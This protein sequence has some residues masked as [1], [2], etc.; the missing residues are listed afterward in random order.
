M[1]WLDFVTANRIEYGRQTVNNIYIHCPFCG[2]DDRS[3][4][5]GL[6]LDSTAF[7]CWR[8]SEHRGRN[9]VRLIQELLGCDKDDAISLARLYFQVNFGPHINQPPAAETRETKPV[10]KPEEFFPFTGNPLEK[11]FT[12]YLEGRGLDPGYVC[13]R[14]NLHWAYTGEYKHRIIIPLTRSG[15]WLA[16]QGRLIGGEG[17]RYWASHDDNKIT[18][19]L[20]DYDNLKGGET[21]V[22]N[23]GAFDSFKIASCLLPSVQVTCLFSKVVNAGQQRRA[24]I[25]LL[26]KYERVLIA[27]DADAQ[28]DSIKLTRFLSTFCANVDYIL[29]TMKDFGDMSKSE[30]KKVINSAKTQNS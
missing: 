1:S 25:E 3:L 7:G 5:M 12:E 8:S 14:F 17:A 29:P 20:L 24:L 28:A 10:P 16:W 18:D 4:N 13:P 26:P 23:E 11:K 19:F 2:P 22:I 21:L 6:A 9:P 30:I 27:L 15:Q